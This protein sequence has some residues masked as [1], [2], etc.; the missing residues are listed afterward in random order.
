VAA[1]QS[2]G[3]CLPVLLQTRYRTIVDTIGATDLGLQL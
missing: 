1:M 3:V 2:R